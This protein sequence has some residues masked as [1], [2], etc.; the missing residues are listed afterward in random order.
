MYVYTPCIKL[1]SLFTLPIR[2]HHPTPLHT[3]TLDLERKLNL[4]LQVHV[5][6]LADCHWLGS[7]SV[8]LDSSTPNS[9]SLSHL[10]S[11]FGE[12]VAQGVDAD[13]VKHVLDH[14]LHRERD[15]VHADAP[16]AAGRGVQQRR[17]RGRQDKNTRH[18]RAGQQGGRRQR[19]GSFR[20]PDESLSLCTF[21][22]P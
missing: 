18:T 20:L 22:P 14:G 21:F 7:K 12:D 3:T 16:L 17:L 5:H 9:L 2:T 19:G 1:P 6:S 11:L 4:N 8:L 13:A 10:E 15:V